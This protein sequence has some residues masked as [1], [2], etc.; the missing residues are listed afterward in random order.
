MYSNKLDIARILTRAGAD[1]AEP[2]K[3]GVAPRDIAMRSDPHQIEAITVRLSLSLSRARALLLNPMT[4]CLGLS[5]L[6]PWAVS[7]RLGRVFGLISDRAHS[8][9]QESAKFIGAL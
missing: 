3:A 4:P 1:A 9:A 6:G 7:L 5:V 8:A 2:N